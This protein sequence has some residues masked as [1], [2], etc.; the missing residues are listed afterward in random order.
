MRP[1][2][3]WDK[4]AMAMFLLGPFAATAFAQAP[5]PGRGLYINGIV[6]DEE[7]QQPVRAVTVELQSDSGNLAAVASV[8]GTNGQFQFNG[9]LSANY[10]ILAHGSGYEPA[11]VSILLGGSPLTNVL[12]SMRRLKTAGVAAPGDRISAHQLS[13]PGKARDAFDKGARQLTGNKP[14]YRAAVSSFQRAIKEFPDYYEA[15]AAM[16]IAF[17]HL[18][19]K[20]AA[21]QA[22]GKSVELSTHQYPDALFLLSE[23]L[24]DDGRFTEALL[25]ARQCVTSDESSWRGYLELARALAGLKHMAEAAAVAIKASELNPNNA[26]TFLV[27]GNIHILEHNYAAVVNDF[28]AYLKL[29]PAGPQSDSVRKSE[30]QAR[31]AMAR[32]ATSPANPSAQ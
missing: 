32:T 16:G 11:A 29:E 8:S 2:R 14:D 22:L 20:T 24:N 28:D 18:G 13:L 15:Y 7:T 23:M 9:V 26:Q 25:F 5:T 1:R 19:D 27:L 6:R 4:L 3:R 12:V 30:E 17:H 31:Q 10:K 21:E